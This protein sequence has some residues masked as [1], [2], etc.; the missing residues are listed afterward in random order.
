MFFFS[1]FVDPHSESM[2]DDHGKEPYEIVTV[3]SF[4]LSL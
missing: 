2:T 3:C 1:C 4:G